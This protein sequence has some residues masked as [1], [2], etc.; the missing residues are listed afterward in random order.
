MKKIILYF[1]TIILLTTISLMFL[2][3][4]DK[5]R[6]M[7][8]NE[9]IE[10]YAVYSL[11]LPENITFCNESMPLNI[12]DVNERLDREIHVNTH[13]QSQTL[14]LI[15]RSARWLPLIASILTL[16]ATPLDFKYLAMAESGFMNVVSPSGAAGY[17]QFL[18][19]TGKEYGLEITDEIDERY[20]VE[21][22]TLAATKYF[23][24]SYSKFN[25]WT[26]VAASYNM[27]IEG[28]SSLLSNQGVNSYYDL[29]LSDETSRYVF[30]ILALKTICSNPN[31]YGFHIRNRDLYL[32]YSYNTV[33]INSEIKDFVRFSSDN[34]INYKELKLLNPWLRKSN[35]KNHYKKEYK[36]KIIKAD[37]L[38]LNK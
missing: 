1:L 10:N 21:H 7:R 27:G 26:L 4:S 5:D 6:I 11:E 38:N 28:L 22:A 17:W 20:H 30:R 2:R 36:I 37:N 3:F 23:K 9:F 34:N 33:I 16:N 13:W 19:P 25:N 12:S 35:L 32:P 24:K 8:Q 31:L 18:K 14:L 29:L 15:K